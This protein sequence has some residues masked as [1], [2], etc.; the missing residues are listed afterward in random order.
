M[1]YAC[2]T[3]AQSAAVLS[4]GEGL[5][6]CQVSGGVGISYNCGG[7]GAA[8]ML[9]TRNVGK[10]GGGKEGGGEW[11]ACECNITTC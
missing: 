9:L 10:E 7:H 2:M 11:G 5:G 6:S 1:Q 4:Q 8:A 3:H